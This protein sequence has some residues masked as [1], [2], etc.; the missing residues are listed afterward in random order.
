MLDAGHLRKQA[1]GLQN[2]PSAWF[3]LTSHIFQNYKENA[4][5]FQ[6]KTTESLIFSCGTLISSL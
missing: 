6:V 3:I 4:D 2:K 5:V 1:A